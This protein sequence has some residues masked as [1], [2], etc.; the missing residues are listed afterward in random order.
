MLRKLVVYNYCLSEEPQEFM[1][2][3]FLLKTC[4]RTLLMS[5]AA[6]KELRESDKLEIFKGNEAYRYLLEIICGLKSELLAENEIVAQFR[7]AYATYVQNEAQ[8][9]PFIMRTL[10]RL[11]KDAKEIRSKFLVNIG[12][13]SYCALTRK[14]LLDKCKDQRLEK[15]VL[16]LGSGKLAQDLLKIMT[17]KFT[18]TV[19]ARNEEMLKK[20]CSEYQVQSLNFTSKESFE[21][22]PI[23][24]NT[25]G[26][27]HQFLPDSFFSHYLSKEHSIFVDL[28]EPAAL[29][30]MAIKNNHYISLRELYEKGRDLVK[31]KDQKIKSA[32]IHIEDL[33]HKRSVYFSELQYATV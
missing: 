11:F 7:E 31:D 19:S 13:H 32:L 24:I 21:D 5:F 3:D 2:G 17:K 6:K 12:Q 23:I 1:E 27:D 26:T 30:N 4:Q 22:Y 25:I 28:A 29:K 14:I 10:E 9:H 18:I 16:I 15:K 8:R 33:T 20:L